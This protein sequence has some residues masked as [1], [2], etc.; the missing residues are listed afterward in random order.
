MQPSVARPKVRTFASFLTKPIPPGIVRKGDRRLPGGSD[1]RQAESKGNGSVIVAR[2][3]LSTELNLILGLL[4]WIVHAQSVGSVRG[5]V[6]D[7]AGG[8]ISGA[9]VSFKASA[10]ATLTDSAGAFRIV[11]VRPGDAI[12]EVRRL[13]YRPVSARVTVPA[14]SELEVVVNLA[15]VAEQ[16]AP[17]QVRARAQPYDSRL[18]GFME[19]KSKHVGYFVTRERLDQMSSA[20]FI[21]ALREMP[22]VSA[23]TLRG[24]VVTV[25]LRGA[26][27]APVFYMD[28]FPATAGVM[29][30]GMIDLS[31]VEGIEVYS[32]M[33]S[34][35]AEFMTVAGGESCGVIAVWSRP[36]RPKP[37][38]QQ[39]VSVAEVERLVEEMRVFTADEVTRPV[40]L[41]GGGTVQPVYPDS[42]WN[43][44][45]PGRVVAQF[46]VDQAG[47]IE[48]GTV[49]IASATHPAF[50]S[51]VRVALERA[52][53]HPALLDGEPVRQLV[54]LPFDFRPLAGPQDST[55]VFR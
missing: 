40:A 39:S 21:D 3:L 32:G 2:V 19:R 8:V 12:L 22:G 46:I 16:L 44:G 28:G 27:C 18:A 38:P 23:R 15:P 41:I 55:A 35:P 10:I 30:L 26:R 50:A 47:K 48:S 14:G 53:F 51:A 42:L 11:D 29:D 4:P 1:A 17:V 20:R 13:G 43:A 6:H 24:G 31:G 45:I 9:H 36:F 49:T 7:S 33:S 52:V 37:R 54:E 34:I 25:S 5:M